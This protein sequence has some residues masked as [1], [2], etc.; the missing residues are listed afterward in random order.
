MKNPIPK[1]DEAR[2]SALLRQARPTPDLPPG[3]QNA[4]WRRLQKAEETGESRSLGDWLDLAAG[5][6]LRPRYALA[7]IAALLLL[8]MGIGLVDGIHLSKQAAQE[9]YL[10]VVSPMTMDHLTM[11]HYAQGR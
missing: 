10:A 1:A 4:V 5:W 8:G 11:G 7:G 3:F 6:L 9:R 2:L